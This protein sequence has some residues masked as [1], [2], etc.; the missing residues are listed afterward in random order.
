MSEPYYITTAIA[1]PNG[2]Q[3]FTTNPVIGGPAV[4]GV[5][6][7]PSDLRGLFDGAGIS[8]LFKIEDDSK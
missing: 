3:C 5:E 7:I 8:S 2:P 6:A 1:Y 4:P